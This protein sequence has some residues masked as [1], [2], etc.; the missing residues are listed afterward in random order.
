ML[1]VAHP[2]GA[3]P[4]PVDEVVLEVSY[5]DGA[6]WQRVRDV[7]ERD[8]GRYAAR[9]DD[10]GAAGEFLSLRVTASDV[11]GN[12]VEQEIIRAYALR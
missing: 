1:T 2:E 6:S 12:T 11:E 9:L 7:R 8:G 4:S 3:E 10:R 5:D